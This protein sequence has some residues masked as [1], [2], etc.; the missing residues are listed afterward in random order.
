[1]NQMNESK[2]IQLGCDQIYECLS[3]WLMLDTTHPQI[4]LMSLHRIGIYFSPLLPAI[5]ILKFFI[6][7]YLK[8]VR[9]TS[10]GTYNATA[11]SATKACV[12][13]FVHRGQS[14]I[15][16]LLLQTACFILCYGKDSHGSIVAESCVKTLSYSRLLLQKERSE[17]TSRLF[18]HRSKHGIE[19]V[20]RRVL[21]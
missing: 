1:M 3:A 10:R 9:R 20:T 19:V 6:L 2:E 14:L 15:Q 11:A 21:S 18:K 5:Q 16:I 12:T 17:M 13:L 8:K 4:V 7:F